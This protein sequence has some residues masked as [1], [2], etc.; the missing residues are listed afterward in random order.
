MS[1]DLNKTIQGLWIGP[2]LSRME[3]LSISSF[4]QNGHDYHLYVYDEVKN[5]PAGTVIRDANEILP[6]AR[7]F[8]YKHRPSY[9]GFSNFFRYKLLLDRG[10]WWA[11]SDTVCLKAFDFPDEYVFSSEIDYR[12]VEVVASGIIKVPPGSSIMAYAWK[13]CEK[14]NP[15][16][17]VWGEIGPKLMARAV[18]K[19]SLEEFKKGSRVFSP[20]DY[21][22]WQ[23]VLQPDAGLS[24]D[25]C[26]FAIH[27]WNEMW[28]L[29]GQDK[30]AQYHER[31]LYEQLKKTYLPAA[32]AG[33]SFT[34]P[35]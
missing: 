5:V 32:A 2:E 21:E 8:Q 24:L 17:L 16:R 34:G 9:A 18:R 4:L 23:T 35:N 31:C 6:A 19:F 11:D 20:V 15:S 27:L 22:E 1:A 30:N 26:T 25:D 7:I 13:A 10:G 29:A 28:R 3:Q 33:P 14:K 12:G